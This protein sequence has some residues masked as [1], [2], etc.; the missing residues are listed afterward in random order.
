MS[1]NDDL[2]TVD[3]SVDARYT[4]AA[5]SVRS[6]FLSALRD[7]CEILAGRCT[8]CALVVVPPDEHCDACGGAIGELVRVG[9]NGVVA[10]LTVI[11][12]PAPFAFVRVRLDGADTDLVH[13][14]RDLTGLRHGT[15][16]RPVWSSERTGTIRD[17]ACFEPG[18]DERIARAP[19]TQTPP[20][21]RV[22]AHLH[23]RYRAV[24]GAT[25]VRF[26]RA[27]LVAELTGNRCPACD[28]VFVPPRPHCPRCFTACEHWLVLPDEGVVTA[29]V[30]V[31][32]PFSGQ[33]VGI[34]YVLADVRIDGA[35]GTFLHL[36]GSRGS[37]GKLAQPEGGAHVGMRVRAI[38]RS[39][40]ERRG[41]LNDD[42]DHFEPTG[43]S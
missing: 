5:G 9:P 22:E 36:V 34:P 17:I 11:S 30:I 24:V 23:M 2:G 12:T 29:F 10:G 4:H 37:D 3:L 15:R 33:E 35:D 13:V 14:A 7:E 39:P 20:V 43:E 32:V 38:W 40:A 42:I 25:E 31:N 28:K 27:L 1:G 19:R 21:T 8:R 6:R 41:L 26:R 16:V 18:E